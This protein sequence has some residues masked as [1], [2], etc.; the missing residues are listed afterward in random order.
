MKQAIWVS[1]VAFGLVG[2][3]TAWARVPAEDASSL[4]PSFQEGDVLT[5]DQ[6]EKLLAGW[7]AETERVVGA[8]PL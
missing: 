2:A 4:M 3:A 6:A 7:T 5:F 8:G 1:V